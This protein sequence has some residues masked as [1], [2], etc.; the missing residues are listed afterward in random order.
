M[1]ACITCLITW[2]PALTH[3][4]PFAGLLSGYHQG[5]DWCACSANTTIYDMDPFGSTNRTSGSF[6]K[7]VRLV[8]GDAVGYF[9]YQDG[10]LNRWGDA[11]NHF[12]ER[13][14]FI[15]GCKFDAGY[16]LCGKNTP[17]EHCVLRI[18]HR[19]RKKLGWWQRGF[20]YLDTIGITNKFPELIDV[21]R[22]DDRAGKTVLLVDNYQ[23]ATG[24]SVSMVGGKSYAV[25]PSPIS[26]I[27]V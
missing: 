4:L 22:F 12:S 18:V 3:D 25:S 23:N 20:R 15:M 7:L 24:L 6:I 14:A 8:M 27:E 16:R 9:G 13:Q 5:D 11:H 17:P 10:E 19:L 1:V 21:R 2:H 26:A